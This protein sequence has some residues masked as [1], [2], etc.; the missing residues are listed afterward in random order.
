MMPISEV[1]MDV[2]HDNRAGGRSSRSIPGH[3][4]HGRLRWAR[5]AIEPKIRHDKRLLCK[6][7]VPII[8]SAEKRRPQHKKR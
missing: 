6:T 4:L 2:W 7:E 5:F 3:Q 8:L 1:P